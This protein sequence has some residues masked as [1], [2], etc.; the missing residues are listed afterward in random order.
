MLPGRSSKHR[1]GAL[2]GLR[3]GRISWLEGSGHECGARLN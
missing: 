2:I 3:K 1:N